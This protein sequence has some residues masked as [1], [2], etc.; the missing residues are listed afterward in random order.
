MGRPKPLVRL[1]GRPLLDLVLST[2]RR[3]RAKHVVVVL[4]PEADWIRREVDLHGT[5]VVVNDAYAAGMSTSLGVGIRAAPANG[6][7]YLVVLADQPLVSAATLDALIDRW[8]ANTSKIVIPT[9][10]RARGNPVLVDASLSNE[11]AGISGDR[12]CRSIF[13]DHE[14]EIEEV[15]VDDPGVLVDLDTEEQVTRAEEALDRGESLEALAAELAPAG[16]RFHGRAAPR[17]PI[18]ST[19][20]SVDVLAAALELRSRGEP[21]ALATVVR[22]VRPTSGK[23]GNKAIVTANKELRGWVGGS[24]AESAVIAESLAAMR[25]GRP[26]VLRLSRNPGSLSLA[27][28]V[29]DYFM[30]CHSGGAMDIY[31]EPHV[32]KP[33]L[34]IVGDS[35]VAAAL[36]SLGRL[37][38]YR[39]IAVGPGADRHIF[40]DA[41]ELVP[42]LEKL[43]DLAGVGTYAVVATMGRYDETAI[44]AL[45]PSRAAYVGLVA[46]RKRA[47]VLFDELEAAGV[48]R[49]SL[50]RVHNPAGIEMSAETPEEIALSIAAEITKLRRAGRRELPVAPTAVEA[51]PAMAVDPV[52]G[53]EVDP[54]TALSAVHVG[55]TYYFCSDSCR[56]RFVEDPHPF[57]T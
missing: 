1:Q 37:M 38:D 9:Y 14:D 32:P 39:V 44:R 30:E 57:L 53:M 45:A 23:P 5:S 3:S 16:G 11:M 15:P 6:G 43:K 18:R 41:D 4:G 52:C 27:E 54:A 8:S 35:P 26:R 22:V 47:A 7:A 31:I 20:P 42:D 24:C 29:V 48:P 21:F 36:A 34:L 17:P 33:Q 28:G 13:P 51:P 46:S 40:P 56:S 25:D 2:V 10:H 50:N 55:T 12:G 19:R 49:E